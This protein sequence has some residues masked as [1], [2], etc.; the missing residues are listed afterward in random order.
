M[1][2]I[3]PL[4]CHLHKRL[5]Q[6]YF[7]GSFFM[8]QKLHQVVSLF[9]KLHAFIQQYYISVDTRRTCFNTYPGME[10]SRFPGYKNTPDQ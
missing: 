3:L 10:T 6:G 5:L 7:S 2:K 9:S 1:K 8:L 4:A